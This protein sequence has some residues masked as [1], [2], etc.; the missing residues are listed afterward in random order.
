MKL[1][2]DLSKL[3]KQ[4]HQQFDPSVLKDKEVYAHWLAQTYHYVVHSTSLLGFALPHL[5]NMELKHHFE[6]H[7]GE[8]SRHDLLAIK[9]LERLGFSLTQFPEDA[10]TQAFYH[11]QYYRIQ[12]EGGTSLL[13]YILFLEAMAVG[14]GRKAYEEIKNLHPQSVLFLKVHAEED[15]Q[16]VENAIGAIMKLGQAEQDVIIRNMHFTYQI[17]S[18]MLHSAMRNSY[19]LKAA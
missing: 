18:Q 2:Q 5:K 6:Q 4:F 15:P 13:G 1:Q 11:S 7:L 10:L 9:D 3:L 19:S 12:F 16:H 14:W 17:Y 8:E